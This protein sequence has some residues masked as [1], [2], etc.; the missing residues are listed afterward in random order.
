MKWFLNRQNTRNKDCYF[1]YYRLQFHNYILNG[2]LLS[3]NLPRLNLFCNIL[4]FYESLFST[5]QTRFNIHSTVFNINTLNS[6]ICKRS[7]KYLFKIFQILKNV[8]KMVIIP[9]HGYFRWI[10]SIIVTNIF[11]SNMQ[12]N[13][14][15]VSLHYSSVKLIH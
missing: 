11:K 9:G 1:K 15:A 4:R 6:E 2:T 10:S 14:I 13:V 8:C 3:P 7:T 12:I 5:L